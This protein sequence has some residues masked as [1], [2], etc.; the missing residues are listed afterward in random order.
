MLFLKPGSFFKMNELKFFAIYHRIC[1]CRKSKIF[2]N[3]NTRG[4]KCT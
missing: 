4:I 3:K 2:F 1:D